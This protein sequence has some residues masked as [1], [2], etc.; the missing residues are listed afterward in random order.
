MANPSTHRITAEIGEGLKVDIT[1]SYLPGA[2]PSPPTACYGGDP[3]Y[4]PELEVISGIAVWPEDAFSVW[5]PVYVKELAQGWL[6]DEGY[7]M[8]RQHAEDQ[9][10]GDWE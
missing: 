3:G 2:P 1:Y 5:M 7:D 10:H 9:R 8:A 6:D 4:G